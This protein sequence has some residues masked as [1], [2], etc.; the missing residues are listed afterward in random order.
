VSGVSFTPEGDWFAFDCDGVT[1]RRGFRTR[2]DAAEWLRM[3]G[4]K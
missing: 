3:R 1:L 4:P 2:A